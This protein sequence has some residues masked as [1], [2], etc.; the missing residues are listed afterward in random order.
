MSTSN[1]LD[2]ER[3]VG[4]V[5]TTPLPGVSLRVVDDAGDAVATGAKSA[6]IEFKGPNVFQGYW[7]D[8]VRR[9]PEEFTADGYFRS[10]DLGHPGRGRLRQHRRSRQGSD[11]QRRL[12]RVSERGGDLH[13]RVGRHRASPPSSASRMRTSA[14]G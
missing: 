14:S 1:P 9:P 12:Q 11:Y 5:G 8:A 4:T 3:K 13:R 2:G 6:R 7:R 10:G